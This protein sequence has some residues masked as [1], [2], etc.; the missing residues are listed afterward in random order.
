MSDKQGTKARVL[1]LTGLKKLSATEG[2]TVGCYLD[3]STAYINQEDVARLQE[4]A[5]KQSDANPVIAYDKP[6]YGWFV[7]VSAADDGLIPLDHVVA[8]CRKYGY[9]QHFVDLLKFASGIGCVWI[10][11]D[12]DGAR[13]PGLTPGN[14]VDPA[15]WV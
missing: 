15:D 3:A 1:R 2:P 14:M 13:V 5:S 7:H 8:E 4:A 12:C 9:T 11:L 6:G 10:D